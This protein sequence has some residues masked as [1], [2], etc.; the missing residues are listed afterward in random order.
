M[1][2]FAILLPEGSL[3]AVKLMEVVFEKFCS[4]NS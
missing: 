2:W 1:D 3:L 4:A